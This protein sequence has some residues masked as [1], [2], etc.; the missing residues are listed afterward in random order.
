MI[1]QSLEDKGGTDGEHRLGKQQFF[2]GSDRLP[3][4]VDSHLSQFPTGHRDEQVSQP[5]NVIEV[6]VGEADGQLRVPQF[7]RETKG[8]GSGIEGES[9]L[10]QQQAGGLPT[11]TGMVTTCAKELDAHV[12]LKGLAENET[13]TKA[14]GL[15]EPGFPSPGP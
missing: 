4:G 11:F 2:D 12:S 3:G 13:G 8:R 7:G 6:S 9:Y 10:W 5:D 1:L 15:R 14:G